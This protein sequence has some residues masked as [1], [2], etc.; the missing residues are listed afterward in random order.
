MTLNTSTIIAKIIAMTLPHRVE[1]VHGVDVHK[2]TF[3]TLDYIFLRQCSC[4]KIAAVLPASSPSYIRTGGKTAVLSDETANLK[5]AAR[6][7]NIW[8]MSK[9][10]ANPAV[11]GLYSGSKGYENCGWF[12]KR[13]K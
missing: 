9:C 5:L 7:K 6:E 11:P 1:V 3:A 4:W 13:G 2:F 8:G 10:R 12:T